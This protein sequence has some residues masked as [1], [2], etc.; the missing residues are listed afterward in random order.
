MKTWLQQLLGDEPVITRVGPVIVLVAAFLAARGLLD[1][2]TVELIVG[3][4]AALGGG[5]ALITARG[6]VTPDRNRE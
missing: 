3:I 6:K 4:V 1:G 2:S 5:G